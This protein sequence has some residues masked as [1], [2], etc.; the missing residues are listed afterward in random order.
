[1][2]DATPVRRGIYDPERAARKRRLL[3]GEEPTPAPTLPSGPLS[4]SP[5]QRGA[6]ERVVFGSLL[7]SMLIAQQKG[8]REREILRDI[9]YMQTAGLGTV[10]PNENYEFEG[11]RDTDAEV[12]RQDYRANDPEAAFVQPDPSIAGPEVDKREGSAFRSTVNFLFSD[13]MGLMGMKWDDEGFA[14]NRENFVN[15]ITEHPYSTALTLAS[16]VVPIGAAWMKGARIAQRGQKLAAMAGQV[17]EAAAGRG[18]LGTSFRFRFDDHARLVQTLANPATNDGRKLFSDATVQALRQAS[19][20][21]DVADIVSPSAL[22]KMLINDW[23]QERFFELRNLAKEGKLEGIRQKASWTMWRAFGNRYFEKLQDVSKAQ[24]DNMD[25]FF[26]KAQ[27]GRFLSQAPSR[28]NKE[29]NEAI[30]KFWLAGPGRDVGE[31]AKRIGDD[32][33]LWADSMAT[34]WQSLFKEQATEG[35][36][37]D[38]TVSL[39][40]DPGKVGAGFHLPALRRGTHDFEELGGSILSAQPGQYG[41]LVQTRKLDVGKALTGPTTKHRGKFNTQEAVLDAIDALETDP[42]KLTIGGFIKD[43]V[44]FQVHRNFRD[45]I[46]DAIEAPTGKWAQMVTSRAAY[47]AMPNY[48]K[49]QWLDF[50]ELDTVVPGL[51]SRMRRMIDAKVAKDGLD[52]TKYAQ[53]PVIDR[54]VV[55]QF[56]GHAGSARQAS[57]NFAKFFELLTAVHKTSRT[58]LNVPT[59][60]SNITGN[61]MFLA[62]AG[63]N[64]FS[65]QALNDGRR[66][67]K[68]LGRISKQSRKTGEAVDTLMAKDNLI[69]VFGKDRYIKDKFGNQLDLADMFSDEIM[70]DLIESQAFENVEGL[71]HVNNLLK[72]I[73]RLESSG[74]SDKALAGVARS[75]AGVG[76]VPGVRGVLHNMSAAYLSEDM[77]PKMMYATNLARQGWGRD[78]IVRE[79]GRRLPQYRTVGNIQNS[80][81][82]IV[83]PWITFPSE[84]ARILKNN[85]MDN[86]VAMMAWMQAPSVAQSVV[87]GM[88]MGPDYEEYADLIEAAP[89]WAARYQTVMTDGEEA[90]EALGAMGVGGVGAMVGAALGGARGAAVGAVGGAVAGATIGRTLGKDPENEL[91]EFNRAWTLDFLPQSAL[92]P[93]SIHPHE[94]EKVLPSGMGGTPTPGAEAFQTAKDL[95]PVEPFAVFLPLL[96]LYSGRGSFGQEIQAKSGI[97][98][99]NKMALGLL[100]HL[101]PPVIQKYG[102]KL[103][104]PGGALVP[105]GDTHDANGGQMTVPKYVTSTLFGLSAAGL[106][107]LGAR[108]GLGA[109]G[110]GLIGSTALSGGVG[111]MAGAEINTRRL[112]TDL[113][114]MPDP[115]TGEYGDW[116]LDFLANSFFGLNKS[117]KVSPGQAIYNQNLRSKRFG[118]MRK[119]SVKEL[120][121]AIGAERRGAALSALAEIYKTYVYEHGDTQAAKREFMDWGQRTIKSMEGLRIYSGVSEERLLGQISALRAANEELTKIRRQQ[122]AEL[123]AELQQRQLRKASGLKVV[124]LPK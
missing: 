60:M 76:E 97:S 34:K 106:T 38:A 88:G 59:H 117:W 22:R 4:S 74:W 13:E 95:T 63:M 6:D 40:T 16:Y 89:P 32:N 70:R 80:A 25:Q 93:S 101:A 2:A 53:M 71:N 67:A 52:A 108:G 104:G 72:G 81:R 66:M 12:R 120:R 48:A 75:I 61:M 107:F 42:A 85:M 9:N 91:R 84:A 77:I 86:P 99:A 8:S 96:D 20:P 112:M 19:S 103:E 122:L 114:I 105:M 26:T 31:L 55:K 87:S 49:K 78:A 82:R 90:P 5:P 27:F 119:V 50:D 113:G 111:A 100:G 124:K 64:P 57:G 17:P 102:M 36:I 65:P 83:L 3:Y 116:T 54:E 33:A 118:E 121:D 14:W 47:E 94:W 62:M 1:M 109:R 18:L 68:A 46:T 45:I 92:F 69:K 37:D 56:F 35:F 10:S 29:G 43:N 115:R 79:I 23:H 7:N 44:L 58:A 123:R 110:A 11:S 28:L 21:A 30:Y 24:I 51:A 39:F 15:Q 73:E 41:A 98:F